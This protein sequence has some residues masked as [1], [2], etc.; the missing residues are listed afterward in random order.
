MHPRAQLR[1]SRSRDRVENRVRNP[2]MKSMATPARSGRRGTVANVNTSRKRQP[3]SEGR[4]DRARLVR[5]TLN[6]I[7]RPLSF[8]DRSC[9]EVVASHLRRKHPSFRSERRLQLAHNLFGSST[10]EVH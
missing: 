8:L 4:P 6:S 2:P 5:E 9:L 10:R 1:P 7:L 3:P